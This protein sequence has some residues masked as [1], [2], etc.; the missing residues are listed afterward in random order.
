MILPAKQL[1]DRVG[2]QPGRGGCP[3]GV[4]IAVVLG[5][6]A[7]QVLQLAAETKTE[8]LDEQRGPVRCE[9]GVHHCMSVKGRDDKCATMSTYSYTEAMT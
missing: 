4:L 5:I 7:A 3:H 1:E 8:L 2:D 9:F 6:L